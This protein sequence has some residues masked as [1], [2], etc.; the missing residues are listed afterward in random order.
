MSAAQVYHQIERLLAPVRG[1]EIDESSLNRLV[2]LV[3]GI[4]EG[5]SAS[6]A[7]IAQALKR[8]GL[9]GASVESLERQVRRIEN[10]PEVT[11]CVC[12]HPVARQRLLWSRA[13]QLV[14]VMDPTC[15][16]ERV[17]MLTVGVAYRGRTLPLAWAVW[18]ANTPL[19]GERFWQRV[20]ALLDEVAPLL[21]THTPIVW[22]ADRA[23]G[24][25]SFTD[26][27]EARGWSYV[28]RVQ[29]QTHCQDRTGRERSVRQLVHSRGQRAKLRGQVFKKRG[30]RAA[31]VVMY[32][33]RRH[34]APLALVSNLPPEWLLIRLYRQRYPIEATF[35]DFK[36]AGWHW[37]QGQVRDLAHLERLLV[38]MALATWMALT[39][40]SQVARHYLARPPSAQRRTR[41][42]AGK[43]SLFQLG[44]QRLLELLHG[45]CD[46]PLRWALS[47]WDAP[48]WQAQLHHHHAH[49]VVFA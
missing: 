49:A 40:G 45:T 19:S 29:G 48:P 26:P 30:W 9:S 27:I 37:E 32:W 16:E 14:L 28:V 2:L 24:T 21:P 25:P 5:Q 13:S 18:P 15:Q 10:D 17:V 31:S 44:L 46:V 11:A 6:P 3:L 12:V 34:S 20:G 7:R 1:E 38:G 43:Y 23:F 35:R 33:G 39:A 36:S 8:L 42:W 47:D 22:L 41:P 4:V